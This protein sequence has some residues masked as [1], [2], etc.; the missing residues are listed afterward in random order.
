MRTK[1]ECV[2]LL[3]GFIGAML[4]SYYHECDIA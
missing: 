1:K 3:V 2:C 4:F